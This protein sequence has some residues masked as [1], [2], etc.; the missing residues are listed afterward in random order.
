MPS[1]FR[2]KLHLEPQHGWLNDPNGLCWFAGKYHV[3]F[4]YAP[5]TPDGSG[6]KCWGHWQ[7]P[8]LLHWELTGTVLR[9]DHPDD[10]NGVYSGSALVRGDTLHLFYTGN[11]KEE[12][13]FDYITAGRAA[14]VMHVATRDGQHIQ[15][16]QTLL[17]QADYP[18]FC[19]CHVRDPKVWEADGCYHMVL[20]ARTKDNRGCVLRYHSSDLLHWHYTGTVSAG[21]G[22]YMWEC[23]DWFRLSGNDYLSVSPQGIPHESH[24]FQNVYSSGYYRMDGDV[25]RDYR[26]WDAGFD[27][28]APQTFLAPDGRRI[29]IGWMGI[30]DI[31]YSNPTAALG[32]Q[33]CLTLPRELTVRSD[34]VLLQ[35]PVRELGKLR[36]CATRISGSAAVPVQLPFELWGFPDGD[37]TA[38][39]SGILKLTYHSGE[40]HL[41]LSEAA[42]YGRTERFAYLPQ[43]HEIRMIADVSSVEIF[44]NGGEIVFSARM[45]PADTAVML[46][47]IS[48]TVYDLNGMEMISHENSVSRHR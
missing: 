41:E 29:L 45:Y 3:Y 35:T 36:T 16:K 33:H 10:R 24:R 9:P 21:D 2:Q 42:G 28:Y 43:C 20:G 5:D 47:G 32:W 23:P 12:G 19:S 30:G 14:N 34:G 38:E 37:F 13:D 1:D 15:E 4:Q 11:V 48:G 46:S 26:E 6:T 31:P 22:S 7:S 44:L 27:F 8:D 18:P 17:R 39:L 40:A 25:P